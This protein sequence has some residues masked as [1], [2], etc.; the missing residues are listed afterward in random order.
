ML[1]GIKAEGSINKKVRTAILGCV[2]A[3]FLAL[4]YLE[5]TSF[6][7]Y[8]NYFIS[9]PSLAIVTFFTHN[10]VAVSLIIIGMSFYVEFVGA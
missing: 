3:L 1:K 9:T 2:F 6:L 8:I 7:R 10:V 5:N 4:A